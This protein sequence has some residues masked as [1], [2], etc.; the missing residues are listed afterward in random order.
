MCS[1]S[2]HAEERL[3]DNL[4]YLFASHGMLFFKDLLLQERS[5]SGD[6]PGSSGGHHH[7]DFGWEDGV[8]LQRCSLRS[9]SL[10]QAETSK[11]STNVSMAWNFELQERGA[12][13]FATRA[14]NLCHDN[15]QLIV[16]AINCNHSASKNN[17]N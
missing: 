14:H 8:C 4:R 6:C 16:I 10:G 5:H 12:K 15:R 2:V 9:A 13:R 11:A 7:E 1:E 17:C 3:V